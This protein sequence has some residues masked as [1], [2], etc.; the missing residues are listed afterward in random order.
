MTNAGFRSMVARLLHSSL[1][2]IAQYASKYIKLNIH[3]LIHERISQR[4]SLEECKAHLTSV[5]GI[6]ATV[7]PY[8]LPGNR[9]GDF[10]TKDQV[11]SRLLLPHALFAIQKVGEVDLNIR[12]AARLMQVVAG[13]LSDSGRNDF[14]VAVSEHAL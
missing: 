7:I 4:F 13:H 10:A 8:H 9:V 14:A 6:L 5:V 2:S 3:P 1:V 12:S 11:V